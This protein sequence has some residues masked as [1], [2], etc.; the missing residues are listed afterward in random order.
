M[1]LVGFLFA[2]SSSCA[3]RLW[4]G[5]AEPHSV[6]CW[7]R[8]VRIDGVA[9]RGNLNCEKVELCRAYDNI[10][11]VDLGVAAA[12]LLRGIEE[13]RRNDRPRTMPGAA[14]AAVYINLLRM[15]RM[16][17]EQ[18]VGVDEYVRRRVTKVVSLVLH[19]RLHFRPWLVRN[20][21]VP[22]L[23]DDSYGRCL[24]YI[25]RSIFVQILIHFLSP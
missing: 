12:N 25:K 17:L 14:I 21:I 1:A 8:K 5:F 15:Q 23:Q 6:L 20:I 10:I 2:V 16:L 4:E 11:D 3:S 7:G 19:K 9:A 24:K 18:L 22:L 13:T